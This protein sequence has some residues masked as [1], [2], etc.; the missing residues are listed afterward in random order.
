ME[1][2]ARDGLKHH[3]SPLPVTIAIQ[4]LVNVLGEN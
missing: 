1:T 2:L 3:V 4:F